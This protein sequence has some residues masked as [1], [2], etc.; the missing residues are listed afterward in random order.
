MDYANIGYVIIDAIDV[1]NINF[2][3]VLETFAETVRKSNDGSYAVIKY[4]K[5]QPTSI[6]N[7][8]SKSIEYSSL[9]Y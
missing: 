9:K 6:Q 7:L 8:L 3:Q 2:D 4:E 5:P 1:E